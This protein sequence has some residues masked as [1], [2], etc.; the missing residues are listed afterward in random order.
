VEVKT[1]VLVDTRG[2]V[3]CIDP[4]KVYDKL[5][6]NK[7]VTCS[8]DDFIFFLNS[9]HTSET[10]DGNGSRISK[11]KKMFTVVTLV[12]NYSKDSSSSAI[13]GVR[14]EDSK[15][16]LILKT[17]IDKLKNTPVLK[18][19]IRH[20]LK[21]TYGEMY[22]FSQEFYST[23]RDSLIKDGIPLIEIEEI[24]KIRDDEN[25]A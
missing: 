25:S 23:V 4:Y 22:S 24:E 12:K 13:L 11:K 7:M 9:L 16:Y 8:K 18:G 14:Q 1:V 10:S 3:S 17:A 5:S 21:G 6:T 2:H 15:Q 20:T 19:K